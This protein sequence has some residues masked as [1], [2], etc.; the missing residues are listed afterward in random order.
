MSRLDPIAIAVDIGGVV[1]G[2][3]HGAGDN[4]AD[5]DA[6]AASIPGALDGLRALAAQYEVYLLSFCGAATEERTRARLRADCVAALVPEERWV[7]TRTRGDKAKEMR[8]RG[9]ALL[10]D[11]REDIVRHVQRSGLRALRFV[12]AEG[13]WA[14]APVA[15]AAALAAPAPAAT[16]PAAPTTARAAAPKAKAPAVP[17]PERRFFG[18]VAF[19]GTGSGLP[20][21]SRSASATVLRFLDGSAWLFDVGEGT[22]VQFGRS[23]REGRALVEKGAAPQGA[24]GLSLRRVTRIFITH[25]HGDHCFGLPGLLLTLAA[26]AARAVAGEEGGGGDGGDDDGG[27]GAAPA[28]GAEPAFARFSEDY[29]FLEITGPRGLGAFLRACLIASDAGPLGFRYRVTEMRGEGEPE[30]APPPATLHVSE[31]PPRFLRPDADGATTVA[32]GVAAARIDHRVVCY[33][34]SVVEAG[35]A[36]ALNAER[37]KALGAAGKDLGLLKA[38]KDVALADGRVIRAADVTS[39]AAPPRCV[40]HLGDCL[41]NSTAARAARGSGPCPLLARS[42]AAGA[43]VALVVHEATFCDAQV[44]HAVPKGHSTARHAAAYAAEANAQCLALTHLSQRYLPRSSGAE[45]AAAIDELEGEA[46]E[47]LR[48]RGASGCA[49]RC[50]EDFEAISVLPAAKREPG[51]GGGGST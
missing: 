34:Y 45:A 23:S 12:E 33:G 20:T 21:A 48:A 36:G 38:G 4:T 11:D 44:D 9:I 49:V 40:V 22:Q 17:E 35:R 13:G 28:A 51:S 43:A 37:A 8:E 3:R 5:H 32:P 24:E 42:R 15:V 19:L 2:A 30:G 29:E 1:Y 25:L 16:T 10:L 7:F 41:D 14:T 47:E 6:E 39:P 26:Q 50:V 18:N 31:A 46:R 27:P